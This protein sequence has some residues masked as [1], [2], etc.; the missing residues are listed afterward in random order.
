MQVEIVQFDRTVLDLS[1]QW[2]NDEEIR[3]LINAPVITKLEQ[4]EWYRT[5]EFKQDYKIWGITIDKKAIGVC[6]LKNIKHDDTEYWSY[7]G[8]K[9]FWGKGFGS[10]VMDLMEN[11]AK[12]LNLT[13]IWL[14]VL[15]KNERAIRLYSRK[16]YLV[17]KTDE[18]L[19]FMRKQL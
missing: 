5:L 6:G 4:E 3:G 11:E 18:K 13:S 12:K 14:Q 1:W 2:I 15:K 17:E 7:I 10:E 8:E 16:G 19:I 9:E